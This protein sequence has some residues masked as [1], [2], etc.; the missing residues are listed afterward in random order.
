MEIA[1]SENRPDL[2]LLDIMMPGMDGFEVCER[3]KSNPIT[4]DIPVIFVTA[5]NEM[6]DEAKGLDVGAI[7]YIRKPFSLPIVAARVKNHLELKQHRDLLRNLSSMDGLTGIANRRRFDETLEKEWHR[8]ARASVPISIV[9]IDVDS[10]KAYNDHYGHVAGD[11]CLRVVAQV[12]QTCFA[13]SSDLVARYGG[14]EFA[15]ILPGTDEPGAA[16]AAQKAVDEMRYREIEHVR[17][18]AAD[19]LT[20]SAGVASTIPTPGSSREFLIQAADRM[21]YQAKTEGRNRVESVSIQAE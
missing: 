5:L 20:V 12:L 3:L 19:V 9:M 13:R 2:I 11:E 10:F 8:A 18:A 17:S 14:E 4:A 1:T 7:D 6:E 16:I 21:L 15:A